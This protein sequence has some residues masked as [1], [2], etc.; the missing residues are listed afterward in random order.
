M[1]TPPRR[2]GRAA[3]PGRAE[4]DDTHGGDGS[5][6]GVRASDGVSTPMFGE[7]R[8][9][10][11][12]ARDKRPRCNQALNLDPPRGSMRA[13]S[14]D[15]RGCARSSRRPPVRAIL[16]RYGVLLN[17]LQYA[18]TRDQRAG[19]MLKELRGRRGRRCAGR[20]AARRSPRSAGPPG[21]EGKVLGQPGHVVTGSATKQSGDMH[22]YLGR[23]RPG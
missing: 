15:R 2:G 3:H 19:A 10:S 4:T 13:R 17:R 18:K 6:R 16:T 11:R 20:R 23:D 12:K 1:A 7:R 9:H 8:L 14:L 21:A 22:G 5:Y